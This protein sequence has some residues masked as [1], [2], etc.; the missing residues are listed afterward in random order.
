[1]VVFAKHMNSAGHESR[2]QFS[3]I[4]RLSRLSQIQLVRACVLGF[5]DPLGLRLRALCR[6]SLHLQQLR[7]VGRIIW[8]NRLPLY[9]L[10][11]TCDLPLDALGTLDLNPHHWGLDP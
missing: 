2:G 4:S 5:Y 1:M 3:H 10:I 6:E 7:G 8:A 9:T 11:H